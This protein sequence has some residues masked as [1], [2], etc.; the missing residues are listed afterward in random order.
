[1]QQ[2][3]NYE[4][5]NLSIVLY[6]ITQNSCNELFL[7]IVINHKKKPLLAGFE[8]RNPLPWEDWIFLKIQDGANSMAI[9]ELYTKVLIL[10]LAIFL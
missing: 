3:S 9:Y 2:P 10:M 4:N 5:H 7:A 1:M 8:P 6:F